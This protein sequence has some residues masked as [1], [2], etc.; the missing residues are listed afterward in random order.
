MIG[1]FVGSS[2]FIHDDLIVVEDGAD[3]KIEQQEGGND[4]PKNMVGGDDCRANFNNA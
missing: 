3:N 4:K 1:E 2:L